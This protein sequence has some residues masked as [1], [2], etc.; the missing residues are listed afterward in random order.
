MEANVTTIL[1]YLLPLICSCFSAIMYTSPWPRVKQ[2]KTERTTGDL[3]PIPYF[4][5]IINGFLWAFYG[6]LVENF[7]ILLINIFGLC[8]ALYYFK[9]FSDFT[10]EQ[11]TVRILLGVGTVFLGS[12]IIYVEVIVPGEIG[13]NHLGLIASGICIIMFGSPLSTMLTVIE[14]K[15][16]ESM[17][18]GLSV[19]GTICSFS[20]FSYGYFMLDDA[21]VWFPNFAGLILSCLQLLL[22]SIYRK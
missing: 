22:F 10:L 16:T 18:F 4:S 8:C 12:V 6:F 15:S 11:K 13:R 5:M 9:V 21:Y 19:C 7:N 1:T 17:H 2:I 14:K 3:S 20:W